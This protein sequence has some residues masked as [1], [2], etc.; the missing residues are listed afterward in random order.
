MTFYVSQ[1]AHKLQLRMA[2]LSHNAI[3]LR[4]IQHILPQDKVYI[5]GLKT[6]FQQKHV[7]YHTDLFNC[8]DNLAYTPVETAHQKRGK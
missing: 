3:P 2:K 1:L 8:E 5:K 6:T 4:R 7:W